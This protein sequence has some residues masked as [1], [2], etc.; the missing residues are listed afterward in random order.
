MNTW[1]HIRRMRWIFAHRPEK[2]GPPLLNEDEILITKY[3]LG[4]LS[5]EAQEE[6]EVR[7]FAEDEVFRRLL[8]IEEQLIER[9]A[10][11][12]LSEPDRE[13]F[14]RYFLLSAERRERLATAMA[15]INCITRE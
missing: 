14:E 4:E 6:L 10:Q 5:E 13:G 7:Y 8:Y 9:Y 12:M 2:A 11:G 15:S 1:K 3:L